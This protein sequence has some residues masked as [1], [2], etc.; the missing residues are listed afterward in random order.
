ML[1]TVAPAGSPQEG[2]D[3]DELPEVELHDAAAAAVEGP[4]GCRCPFEE[5]AH[6]DELFEEDVPR[7]RG[8][9]HIAQSPAKAAGDRGSG[10]VAERRCEGEARASTHRNGVAS[11]MNPA[12]CRAAWTSE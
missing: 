5:G 7:A 4:E 9:E 2:A 3:V 11:M 8:V 12:A 1:G 10:A 6:P